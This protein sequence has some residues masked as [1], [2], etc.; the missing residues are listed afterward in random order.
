MSRILHES[1]TNFQGPNFSSHKPHIPHQGSLAT[2]S[3]EK[4]PLVHLQKIPSKNLYNDLNSPEGTGITN[5]TAARPEGS[6]LHIITISTIFH[7]STSHEFITFKKQKKIYFKFKCQ[8][9]LTI[10]ATDNE[11]TIFRRKF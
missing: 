3:I 8:N 10:Q 5:T 7:I 1:T 6:L 2:T 4:K 9:Y 11:K